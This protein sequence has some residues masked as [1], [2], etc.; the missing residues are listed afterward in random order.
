[1]INVAAIVSLK[2]LP[3]TAEYGLAAIFF[4]LAAAII[5]FIPVSLVSAELATG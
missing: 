1:M 2:N 5:F 4:N 3:V